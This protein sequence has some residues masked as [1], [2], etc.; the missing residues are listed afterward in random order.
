MKMENRIALDYAMLLVLLLLMVKLMTGALVHEM[1][2]VGFAALAVVHFISS[3]SRVSRNQKVRLALTCML[4]L[5][6][7]TTAASGVLL[8]VNLF[9]FL[10]IPYRAA[11]YSVHTVAAHVLLVLSITHLALH[12]KQVRAFF[13][14]KKKELTQ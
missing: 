12:G 14:N 7:V 9:R 5:A 10:N 11:F 13:R 2:G 4:A 8:S 1:L 3:R 6:L